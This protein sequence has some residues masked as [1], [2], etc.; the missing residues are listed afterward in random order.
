MSDDSLIFLVPLPLFFP[1]SDEESITSNVDLQADDEDDVQLLLQPLQ[2]SGSI[3]DLS[4]HQVCEVSSNFI[5]KLST[6]LVL[7]RSITVYHF[8]L[9]KTSQLNNQML[10]HKY[11]SLRMEYDEMKVALKKAKKTGSGKNRM[12]L[13]E[14]K[15]ISLAGGR[16]L[17][18]GE[19]WVHDNLFNSPCPRGLDPLCKMCYNNPYSQERAIIAELYASLSDDLQWAL[20]DEHRREGFR[21]TVCPNLLSI[22]F[23]LILS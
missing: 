20:A 15:L 7:I 13:R 14:D 19:L 10:A 1:M 18:V 8:Q 5:F 4:V 21:A 9:L 3:N 17:V 22:K 2:V 11:R 23:F 12:L 16:F 6:I